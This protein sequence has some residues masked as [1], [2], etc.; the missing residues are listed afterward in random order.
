M[1]TF[2]L[3]FQLVQFL[4]G[5]SKVCKEFCV[6]VITVTASVLEDV[7]AWQT[8]PLENVYPIVFLDAIRIKVRD[9]GQIVNKAIYL[10]IGFNLDGLKDVLG[11]W[12]AQ[13]E[14]AKFWV[15]VVTELRNRG[16]QDI[17]IAC[18][19]GLKGFPE[20]IESVFP[21]IQI[22]LCIVHMVRHSLRFV[23]WKDRKAVASD[24][25]KVYSAP[26]AEAAEMEL[27]SFK[28]RWDNKYPMIS[29]LWECNWQGIIPFLS[30]PDYIRRAIYTTNAIESLNHNLRKLTKTR[31]A[32]PSDEAVIKLLYLGL[33]NIAKQ[34]TMPIRQWGLALNQFAI[35][36]PERFPL[37]AQS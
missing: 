6:K 28:E 27:K 5:R 33:Q 9:N 25:K 34:W 16:V 20:A 31:G 32:F 22:Q 36:F 11:L 15:S 17:F 4:G 21:A 8:R 23:S 12:I 14:R 2:T 18:V 1:I 26:N 19:D 7:K 13:S 29:A 30:Y 3:Y 24:L 35:L 10:A 37:G